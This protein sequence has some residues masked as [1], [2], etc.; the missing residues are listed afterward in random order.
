MVGQP[1]PPNLP[2]RN[3]SLVAGLVKRNQWLGVSGPMLF[4]KGDEGVP[5]HACNDLVQQASLDA[6]CF[7]RESSKMR[8]LLSKNVFKE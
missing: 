3:K 2:P 8:Y 4:L 5:E 1:T 7:Q 6:R